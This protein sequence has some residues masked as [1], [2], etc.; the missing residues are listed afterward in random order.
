MP[1][2]PALAIGF[3]GPIFIAS[4]A[5]FIDLAER[6]KDAAVHFLTGAFLAFVALLAE[7]YVFAFFGPSIPMQ[8][9]LAAEAFLF[10]AL[11]E[12]V[13]KIAQISELARRK[14]AS[15]R[16][17]VAIGITVAAGFAGAENIIYLCRYSEAVA[18]LLLIR[19]LTAN[20]LHL[21]VGVIASSYVFE[22]LRDEAKSHYLA[23]AVLAAT[24][25]HGLYDYLI[26]SSGG[27][28]Y[29]FIFVLA[30]VVAWAWRLAPTKQ[31]TL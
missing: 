21:A 24:M 3:L 30:F 1:S 31:R 20:P 2:W 26:M 7:H 8:Y 18:D 14:A 28:S 27:R 23:V 19:T 6:P 29:R 9:H 10:V 5:K 15:L 17:T 22:A 16:E 4:L 25:C 13:V 11:T 12:E